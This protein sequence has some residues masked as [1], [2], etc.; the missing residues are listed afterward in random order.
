MSE[1]VPERNKRMK[2]IIKRA[3]AVSGLLLGSA[4][5]SGAVSYAIAKK[6]VAMAMDRG[7]QL[8]ASPASI[9][10]EP[11]Q[12]AFEKLREKAAEELERKPNETVEIT[13]RDGIRLVGHWSVCPNAKRVLI[14]VHG[15]RSS[16]SR[17][18]GLLA[19][20]FEQNGCSVLYAE[21]RGQNNSGGEYMGFGLT[22][23]F[24][25]VNWIDWVNEKTGGKFPIYLC[26]VSMGASTVLMTSAFDLSDNVHGIIADCGYTS[27]QAIWKHVAQTNLHMTYDKWLS[28]IIDEMCRERIHFHSTDYSCTQALA[29]S[30]VP[31]LF[32]HGTDDSFVPVEMTYENYKACASPKRLL[33]VPGAD[34][35]MSYVV[36]QTLYEQTVLQ[37]WHDYDPMPSDVRPVS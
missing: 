27:P 15:W 10:G 19:E 36:D 18:F 6:L 20:F 25:C 8:P 28:G 31:V 21:Q 7:T 33:V 17:D 22:E 3:V 34:H 2:S 16:W 30:R 12:L 13:A 1:P 9:S 29:D 4:A 32:I 24:D 11:A 26:G 14:A 5:V 23:R 35:G 37:F